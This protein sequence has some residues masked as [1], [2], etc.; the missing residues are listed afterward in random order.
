[1]RS[2]RA[3]ISKSAALGFA[4]TVLLSRPAPAQGATEKPVVIRD[5]TVIDVVQGVARPGMTIVAHGAHLTAVTATAGAAIPT[6]AIVIEATGKYVIPGLWDMHAHLGHLQSKQLVTELDLPLYVAHGVTGVRDMAGC[7]AEEEEDIPDIVCNATRRGISRDVAANRLVA[8]RVIAVASV[9]VNGPVQRRWG[10]RGGWGAENRPPFFNPGTVPEGRRLAHF[11]ASRWDLDFVKI[12]NG[13]PR[14]AYF[15]FMEEAKSVGLSAAGH[16]PY[17]VSVIEASDAGQRSIEHAF[18]L[19]WDCSPAGVSFREWMVSEMARKPELR[20][21]SQLLNTTIRSEM[22]RQHSPA[23]CDEV[24]QHLTRNDTWYCPTHVTRKFEAFAGDPG[25]MNDPRLKYVTKARKQAWLEDADEMVK[26]DPTP[27]GR[28]A[29]QEMYTLGLEI[30]KRAHAAGVKI[31]A[32]SDTPD[33]YIFPG[34]GLLDELE[35]LARAGL[36][37]ADVLKAAT[38]N[39]AAFMGDSALYG[40]IHP[41]KVADLVLLDRDPLQDIRATRAVWSVML[42]GRLFDRAALRGL[43]LGVERAVRRADLAASRRRP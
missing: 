8:P 19:V 7:L 16:V 32:G 2:K 37:P 36:S 1:M 35:A 12:Y 9:Q 15:A 24:F 33:S 38:I 41:G 40:S 18:R 20:A 13:I 34:S 30:T 11:L 29:F 23:M 17:A 42:N 21:T 31:L 10:W 14:E 22:V 5:V 28:R 25:Y 39:P 27:E 43:L 4:A 26:I 6:G 3:R